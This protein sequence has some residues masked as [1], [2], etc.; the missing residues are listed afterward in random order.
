[1][2]SPNGN[3]AADAGLNDTIPQATGD[4]MIADKGEAYEQ[5]MLQRKQQ[6]KRHALMSLSDYWDMDRDTSAEQEVPVQQEAERSG[7]EN[8]YGSSAGNSNP[9]LHSYRDAQTVLTSF[10]DNNDYETQELKRQVE[11]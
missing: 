10:Y 9:A 11:E 3:D 5:A 8:S 6:E 1:K 7:I 4:G 2:P